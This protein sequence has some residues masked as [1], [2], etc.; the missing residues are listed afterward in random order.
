MVQDL[1]YLANQYFLFPQSFNDADVWMETRDLQSGIYCYEASCTQAV[2]DANAGGHSCGARVTWLQNALGYSY[3]AA[4]NLVYTEFPSICCRPS[5]C[6]SQPAS[7]A[8]CLSELNSELH[9]DNGCFVAMQQD[10]NLV[11]YKGHAIWASDT[12][13]WGA[14][15]PYK[16]WVQADGN[17]VARDRHNNPIWA[18]GTNGIGAGPPYRLDMQDDCNLVLFDKTSSG[19]WA[20]GVSHG[21]ITQPS[22][23][24]CFAITGVYVPGGGNRIWS[25]PV[26]DLVSCELECMKN[27]D[28][29]SFILNNLSGAGTCYLYKILDSR[30]IHGGNH[31]LG[32][33]TRTSTSSSAPSLYIMNAGVGG[34]LSA[35]EVNP[36]IMK[37]GDVWEMWK[38]E[39]HRDG[40]SIMDYRGRYL[41][42]DPSGIVTF[43]NPR[44]VWET[45]KIQ[46]VG[47]G[48][49]SIQSCWGKYLKA[50]SN[51]WVFANA[52][53]VGEWEKWR[54]TN[55]NMVQGGPDG[56]YSLG[57]VIAIPL[58]V[59][60]TVATGGAAAGAASITAVAAGTT[61]AVMATKVAA[62]VITVVASMLAS[63]SVDLLK[64]GI[65]IEPLSTQL[66]TAPV[67]YAAMF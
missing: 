48:V 61:T 9:I 45:W 40:Y 52:N 47:D 23:G 41:S 3:G 54:L 32:R 42:S 64:D 43:R 66:A 55:N 25:V 59:I 8:L 27:K 7:D 21:T 30:Y 26:N 58:L 53:S 16:L 46:K 13:G 11:I 28:C 49:V 4:C 38:I 5:Y 10:G 50:E 35:Q 24:T 20:A 33:C 6:S 15:A 22:P 14:G 37:K 39:N 57:M 19:I 17:V 1:H 12:N 51:G 67:A 56:I 44:I 2:W 18:S 36:Y 29:V 65:V 62:T 60:A 34:Y 31:I 63:A